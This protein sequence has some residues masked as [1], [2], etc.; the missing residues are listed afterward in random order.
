MVFRPNGQLSSLSASVGKGHGMVDKYRANL[1]AAQVVL[2]LLLLSHR[3][4]RV[5]VASDE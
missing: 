2:G 4:R 3:L 1:D 5:K